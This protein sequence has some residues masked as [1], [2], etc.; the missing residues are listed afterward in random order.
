MHVSKVLSPYRYES[1]EDL[2]PGFLPAE[3]MHPVM[4]WMWAMHGCGAMSSFCSSFPR[5]R[6]PSVLA[7]Y[8][9]PERHRVPAFAWMTAFSEML[10]KAGM[11]PVETRIAGVSEFIVA[12]SQ[13]FLR[14]HIQ[15]VFPGVFAIRT[16][17]GLDHAKAQEIGDCAGT[18]SDRLGIS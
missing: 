5:T 15:N 4:R 13:H 12:L 17:I 16:D 18:A 9:S 1:I 2:V 10:K 3:N 11:P 6:E 8:T 14:R 7:L